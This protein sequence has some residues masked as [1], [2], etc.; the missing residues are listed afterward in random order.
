MSIGGYI[1]AKEAA[2]LLKLSTSHIGKLCRR[3]AIEYIKTGHDLL[4]S[5]AS[6]M[7]YTPGPR[8]FAAHPRRKND[9]K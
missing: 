1:T 2:K 5:E 7:S 9:T 4:I 6:A 3:G 8:G